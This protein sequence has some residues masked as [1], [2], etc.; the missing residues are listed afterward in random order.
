MFSNTVFPVQKKRSAAA[1]I[2]FA[3]LCCAVIVTVPPVAG[4]VNAGTEAS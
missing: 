1:E 3:P 2:S 4:A